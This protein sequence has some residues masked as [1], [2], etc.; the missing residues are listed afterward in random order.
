M[1]YR[2]C[3]FFFFSLRYV[4]LKGQV[5]QEGLNLNGT[6]QHLLHVDG[7]KIVGENRNNMKRTQLICR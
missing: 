6:H 4:T 1:F 2:Y 5:H 3:F 7:V